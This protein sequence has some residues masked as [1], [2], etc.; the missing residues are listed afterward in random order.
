MPNPTW[1]GIQDSLFNHTARHASPQWRHGRERIIIQDMKHTSQQLNRTTLLLALLAIIAIAPMRGQNT[2]N[3]RQA[4]RLFDECYQK[5]FG[6]Q[7]SSL[8]YSVNLVG[9]YKTSGTIW[10]KG[11]KSKFIESRYSSWNDGTTFYR[12]DAKKKTVEIHNPNSEKKDKY[13]SKFKFVPDN[14]D[15]SI[16]DSKQGYVISLDARPGVSGIKHVKAIV[17][18]RTLAPVMVKIK[19]AFFWANIYI[20]NFS[21][22]HIDDRIFTFP[23]HQFSG[24]EFKDKRPD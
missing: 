5:A 8:H 10:Y 12:C 1:A 9:I 24:W 22:G 14:Y 20:S 21:S 11:K 19:L 15:Y 23:R 2:P 3:A 4:R 18:H 6:P 17:A 13:M 16:A 7:G